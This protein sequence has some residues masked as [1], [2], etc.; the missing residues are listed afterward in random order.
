MGFGP[1]VGEPGAPATA[2]AARQ[3]ML[4][5]ESREDGVSKL[6]I[7]IEVSTAICPC[8][9]VGTQ[10]G[11]VLPFEREPKSTTAGTTGRR[12]RE[13]MLKLTSGDGSSA[14]KRCLPLRLEARRRRH[15]MLPLG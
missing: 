5:S 3:S 8:F 14:I 4:L 11:W 2:T 1:G 6:M 7:A 15:V 10:M 12:Q 9:P 13:A